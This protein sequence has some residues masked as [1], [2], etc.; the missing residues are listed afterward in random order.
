MIKNNDI[1]DPFKTLFKSEN[2]LNPGPNFTANILGKI[3]ELES[4]PAL[5]NKK[6]ESLY[7]WLFSI[8][9]FVSLVTILILLSNLGYIHIFPENIDFVLLPVFKKIVLNFKDIFSSIQLSSTTV[10]IL[11]ALSAIVIFER[12]LRRITL[13]KNTY[14]ISL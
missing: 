2:I 3:A 5:A 7:T 6:N 12:L 10:V 11:T 4:D 13:S 14:L 9:G 8:A 1:N